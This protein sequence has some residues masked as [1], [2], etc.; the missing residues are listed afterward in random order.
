MKRKLLKGVLFSLIVPLAIG[1][2]GCNEQSQVMEITREIQLNLVHQLI[3]MIIKLHL[4][5]SLIIQLS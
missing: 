2:S 3:L 4:Y 1:L 5:Q